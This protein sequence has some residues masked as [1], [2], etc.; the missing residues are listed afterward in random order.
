M[1]MVK[2][3]LS[4]QHVW[5]RHRRRAD[6]K[7]LTNQLEPFLVTHVCQRTRNDLEVVVL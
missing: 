5:S 3:T 7:Q 2:V 1:T 4:L 6:N